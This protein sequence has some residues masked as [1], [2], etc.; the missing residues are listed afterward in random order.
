MK[1]N[2]IRLQNFRCFE[3]LTVNFDPRLTVVVA[4]NGVGKTS[5]LDAI[6]T[7]FGRFLTKLPKVN[8]LA[9][10]ETDIRIE[11]GEMRAPFMRVMLDIEV[12]EPQAPAFG[13]RWTMRR[14]RDRTAKTAKLIA[15][16]LDPAMSG[17]GFKEIDA[18][19]ARLA[20]ADV[21]GQ[22]YFVPVIAY[23]GTNRAIL[24]EV[25]RRRNYKKQFSRFDALSGAL[26][27]DA[28]FKAAF[29]WFNVMEDAE[30]REREARRDFDFRLPELDTVRHAVIRMLPVGFSNPRTE[31]RPLRFVI[32]RL[33]PDGVT[34]TFRLGQ[35]SDG[36]RVT[37]GLVMDLARRMAQA[38]SKMVAG[39][40][41]ILNPLDLPAIALIDEVDLHLHPRWQQ[42]IL[43]DL[44]RTFKGTQFIVTTHSPQVLSTVPSECIRI[45]KDGQVF[46][47]PPGSEGAES[48][49]LL[50]QVLGLA[51]I[52]PL[53]NPATKEL[54]EYLALV[55]LDEWKT[56]R[57][58]EL[59]KILDAR[60]QGYEPALL[61]ADLHIE[62]RKWEL[63]QA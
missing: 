44:M 47:A 59:R 26:E 61:E 32:D 33:M 10:R 5:L 3:Q 53:D 50:K 37:L 57:A 34:R 15:N 58:L 55:D 38:N 24:D 9:S 6:A 60:Y 23:Y 2:S 22:A 42:T 18:Y 36:Y 14:T 21:T 35:L 46:A 20:E 8:G 45:L 19:A 48:S 30:R 27:P 28:R 49:R 11:I 51:D 40:N 7:G 1:L 41:P 52:R 4:E 56:P 12:K 25:Q 31:I 54:K 29:E 43:T 39:G 63:G 17:I 13:V 62:N 16:Q